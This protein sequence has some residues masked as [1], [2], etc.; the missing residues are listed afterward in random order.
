MNTDEDGVGWFT[1][2]VLAVG[3]VL[4]AFALSKCVSRQ[5]TTAVDAVEIRPS[6]CR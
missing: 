3:A 1:W 6:L 4:F 2:T 5:E